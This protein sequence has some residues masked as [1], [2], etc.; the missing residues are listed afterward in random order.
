MEVMPIVHRSEAE[1]AR[2][3]HAALAKVRQGVAVVIEQDQRPVA[4][5]K[6]SAPVRPGW[7]LSECILGGHPK[8]AIRGQLKTS[9]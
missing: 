8:P 5:L 3:L 1:V 2:E 6:P 7:K 4:V 9:H